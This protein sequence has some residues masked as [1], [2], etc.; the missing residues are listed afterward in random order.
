VVQRALTGLHRPDRARIGIDG[1]AEEPDD[2][3]RAKGAAAADGSTPDAEDLAPACS[4]DPDAVAGQEL[5]PAVLAD[6]G[7]L[8]RVLA[9]LLA[10]AVQH[11]GPDATVSVSA[12]QRD[13]RVTIRIADTGRGLPKGSAEHLFEPFQRLGDRTAAST[14]VGLG[15]A[16]AKGLTEAMGGTLT[17]E[18]TP[19]GGLTMLVD[20]PAASA[21]HFRATARDEDTAAAAALPTGAPTGAPTGTPSGAPSG[22]TTDMRAGTAR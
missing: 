16:V 8:E 6:P 17:A 1:G 4:I 11:A 10:N 18:D 21:R 20:L 14:G 22:T 3:N 19:G 9:N 7:L 2:R 12:A 15:L 13:G 5:R